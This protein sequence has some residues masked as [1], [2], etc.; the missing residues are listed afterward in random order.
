MHEEGY[1]GV[2][3][4]F[5]RLIFAITLLLVGL[6]SYPDHAKAVFSYILIDP[7]SKPYSI[8]I[9]NLTNQ[10]V[11]VDEKA[12]RI[13]IIDLET[14]AVI[15]T[16]PVGRGPK[17]VA[18]DRALNRALITNSGDQ[19]VTAVDLTTLAV[20]AKIPV[21]KSPQGIAVDDANHIAV[22]ADRKDGTLT[23]I[24]ISTLK[25]AGTVIVEGTPLDV[26]IDPALQLAVAVHEKDSTVSIIDLKSM[27]VTAVLPVGKKP[28][29]I[30]IN[31]ETHLA[32]IANEIDSSL[33]LIDLRT[34]ERS[35]IPVCKHPV[36]VAVNP[37]DNRALILCDED[38][39]LQLVDLDLKTGLMTHHLG[40]HPKSIAVNSFMN[41]AAVT[42]DETGGIAIIQLPNPVPE[43]M[44]IK[45]EAVMRGSQETMVTVN[46][47]GFI[48]GSK[49][50]DRETTMPFL[51][52]TLEDNHRL[53]VEIPEELLTY[54]GEHLI[55][56]ANPEPEGGISNAVNLT[57]MNPVP[58]ITAFEPAET[59]AGEHALTVN[60]FGTDFFNDTSVS[61][62]GTSRPFIYVSSSQI[63]VTLS[64]DDLKTGGFLEITT[65]NLPPGGGTSQPV[66]FQI[67]NA[68]PV[69]SSLSAT[70][71]QVG[72]GDVLL[73]VTGSHFTASSVVLFEATEIPA[74]HID[75]TRI[76]VTIPA[77][78]IGTAGTYKIRVIS[79][80]PGGGSS[81]SI[82]FTVVPSSPVQPLPEGSFG[83]QYEDIIPPDV[84]IQAYDAR[85]FSIVTGLVTDRHQNP[86]Q[87]VTVSVHG[88]REYGTAS[89]DITGRFSL[90]VEGG[91]IVTIEYKKDGLITSHRQVHVLWNRVAVAE[92][93]TMIPEDSKATTIAFNGD[94]S[95]I[96]SHRSSTIT[97][98]FGSRSLT[99][100]F[101]GDNRAYVRD[102]EGGE[103]V[104]SSITARATE[105]DKEES[106]PAKLPPNSA[107]T[108][109]AEL[110]IDEATNVRFEKPVTVYVDN[111]LRFPVGEAV[112]LGYYDRDRAVWVPADNGVVVVL[113][114]TNGDGVVDG[115]D[116]TG[117]ELPDDLNGN[118]SFHDEA[119][120]LE[121]PV[122]YKP[123]ATYWRV[124]IDHFTPWDCNW[125]YGP[126]GDAVMP[127]G[128]KPI[129]DEQKGE[130][131]EE[132]DCIS[133]FVK[134]PSRTF[135]EDIPIPG[136]GLTLHY[137]S[138]RV[139]GSGYKSVITIPA[140]GQTVPESLQR[141]IVKLDMAGVHMEKTLLP[142]P[143]QKAEFTWDGRDFLGRP[144]PGGVHAVI[145]VEFVYSA[146]YYIPGDFRQAFSQAG[147]PRDMPI[148]AL[149]P[150]AEIRF[151]KTY[152]TVLHLHPHPG[153]VQDEGSLSLGEGWTMSSHHSLNPANP[154][155]LFKGDGS[156]ESNGTSSINAIAG[157][158]TA[159]SGDGGPAKE[160]VLNSPVDVAVDNIGN[161]YIAETDNHCVRKIDT[162]GIISTV[163]GTGMEGFS[164][165]G[166][167]AVTAMLS[168]PTDI[169]VDESG[170]I[171]VV[172]QGNNKIRRIDRRGIITT[173]A[174]NGQYGYGGDG[175]PAT[176]AALYI[177]E[178]ITVDSM[179]NLYVADSNN[180]RIRKVDT[181]G[182]ITT[183]VGN[184][185]ECRYRLDTCG[186]RSPAVSARIGFPDGLTVDRAGNLYFS[187]RGGYLTRIRK[188]DTHG[189]ITTFA[190]SGQSGYSGDGGPAVDASLRYPADLS[191]DSAG[192]I[193]IADI[194][195]NRIRKVNTS[196][197]ITTVAGSGTRGS[198]GDGG[199]A[200]S[201]SLSSPYGAAVDPEGHLYIADTGNNRIR[202]V[203]FSTTPSGPDGT[204][205]AFNARGGLIHIFKGSGL[206]KE[207]KDAGTGVKLQT[208][209][210]DQ[211]SR[212]TS[213]TDRFGN[214]TTIQRDASGAPVSITSPDGIVTQLTIVDD[215]LLKVTYPDRSF[216]SFSYTPGG[217]MTEE[218]DPR[219][220]R[221]IH[222]FDDNGRITDVLDPEGGHWTY[223]R[224]VDSKG[225]AFVEVLTAEGNRTQH[226]E[227]T[228]STDAYSSSKTG[229]T[230]AKRTFKR[231]ADKLTEARTF[232]CG[233]SLALTYDID[234]AHR[235]KY[236][237][238]ATL[239]ST[240]G[241]SW[242]IAKSRTYTD[243][244]GDRKP[245]LLSETVAL[246]GK[247]WRRDND[248]TT[249]TV[250]NVSPVGRT[251]T[252]QYDPSML[253][254]REIAIPGMH[255]LSLSHDNRGR[256]VRAAMGQRSITY[257]YDSNGNPDFVV[258]PDN[259][260]YDYTF[261][262]VG[263]LLNEQRPDGTLI[264]Y[265]YD[266]N[267][268]MTV[269]T[270]SSFVDHGFVYTANDQRKSYRTPLS[271]SYMY[272]YDKER[273]LISVLFPSGKEIVN[274]YRNGRLNSVTSPE[275]TVA[276]DYACGSLLGNATTGNESIAYTYDGSL[277]TADTR[278]GTLN[279]VIRYEYNN[280]FSLKSLTYGGESYALTYDDDG[281]LTGAGAF[282]ITRNNLNGRPEGLSDGTLSINRVFSG[283]GELD[284]QEYTVAGTNRYG[285]TVTRD[286]SGR[287]TQKVEGLGS[288]TSTHDYGYD[289]I[290]RLVEVKKNGI[291]VETYKYDA[292]GNREKETNT[293]KNV[294][295]RVY[296]HSPEDQ[297]VTAGSHICRF[298]LDGFLTEKKVGASVTKYRYSSGGELL[299]VTTPVGTVVGYDHDPFGRR[300]AKRVNGKFVEKYLWAGRTTLLAVY[301]G[302]D[303]LMSRFA[304]AD[305]RMPVS[306]ET[307]SGTYYFMYDQVGSLRAVAD[308]SG[309]VVKRVDYD[310]FGSIQSDSN[311][312][313][314]VP[315]GF[316]GG[317]HDPDTGLVRFGARDYDPAIG[318]WTAKDPID[319]AGGDT[320][321]YGY[322]M[323]DPVNW[324]DPRGLWS[325]GKHNSII[326]R[327]VHSAMPSL[328]PAHIQAI[329]EGS[330]F[331]DTFQSPEYSYIHHM[332]NGRSNQSR[333]DAMRLMNEFI[334]NHLKEYN[335][336]EN[337]G[338]S[339]EAYK[340]LG[341]AL[342]PVM[343]S[344][345]PSHGDFLPWYGFIPLFGAAVHGASELS[346]DD[347]LTQI[348]V[349]RMIQTLNRK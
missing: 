230:G 181:S 220:S 211:S 218:I 324:V 196:G 342:H 224:T 296:S 139:K 316:A 88:H 304:Y 240:G 41:V 335:C 165:D 20:L 51:L 138:N 80:A 188:V 241:Q 92:T 202:K 66:Q 235:F 93:I 25:G 283:F 233:E 21:G 37:L 167:P 243:R 187:E 49:I 148:S 320:N 124:L 116:A 16:V 329:K 237:K 284:G 175:G 75:D 300:I 60:L 297:I 261:D 308:S 334:S 223:A 280:D 63:L 33:T 327:F 134:V 28:V 29:A 82:P 214:S 94:P 12:D 281:L 99:M 32:A 77:N 250:T 179:G 90:P 111:F 178:A 299:E 268:N 65:A 35:T 207:T 86:L 292:Q 287:I 197:I 288:E 203:L 305:D 272:S 4:F 232:P 201:A 166:G 153:L 180:Y 64:E 326:D 100:V 113:L 189:L 275:G 58:T 43:I 31:S 123:G 22:V 118:G 47:N 13:L 81:Q 248:T 294:V 154:S 269:L 19:S 85:R 190:G 71:A 312:G 170:S 112:P 298:D 185:A 325:T 336:N 348:T 168:F 282:A 104:L 162:H 330:E 132:N 1:M 72:S 314:L 3:R 40:K 8:A 183:V 45:P 69:V 215:R 263:R 79:P 57:V 98:Q 200:L 194:W 18:I 212:L 315:F 127:E 136:T 54:A 108:Y 164:G 307:G 96:I 155:T 67:R 289:T 176:A 340:H 89:T 226:Q 177:P 221:F 141:I 7:E 254:V 140:S 266:E 228:D 229:P 9:N 313:F 48:R 343:D 191:A 78:L 199:S 121:D 38:R 142:Q 115:L 319:F 270:T 236:L 143:D 39:S 242:T 61:V 303:N 23:I 73:T 144:V 302:S 151:R 278:T 150:R 290:G 346:I 53:I 333:E 146:V 101:T 158:S 137:A 106:M 344:T 231:S 114:D 206:H 205:V 318:R 15:S 293:M 122:Q 323:N 257:A 68:V 160:V 161:V 217:L 157:G 249:G 227:H 83:K 322:V 225:N 186:E 56:V 17:G 97:D 152:E 50:A 246:N 210:Y 208:F 10:A 30:D 59:S 34:S 239:V 11:V 174:G 328:E 219:G 84:T 74:R 149:R 349:N 129:V 279:Q 337:N 251:V 36:D 70:A 2:G 262:V 271:G 171:Y 110:S 247:T 301:D 216:Y 130:E 46:G 147:L 244:N 265:A 126:P 338:N 91:G 6:I 310:T 245:D 55:T 169:A 198:A 107:F 117:D 182:V 5:R 295:D 103:I 339:I 274:T 253:R 42:D 286:P 105:F 321:L 341:M 347:N 317:L 291:V 172:D 234:S 133:S 277:V 87:G 331:A 24:D 44:S 306:M 258:T 276:Y 159:D 209:S 184:G 256:L 173:V 27:N 156:Q 345:S 260:I 285:W 26:A 264:Q 109:C 195:D 311:P 76:E 193:Y 131:C 222:R 309:T 128:N 192:N 252:M 125:P 332:R 52:A 204:D 62:N 95:K 14:G 255:A 102:V 145:E 267:G 119:A 120:G 135:H 213:V 273:K 259:S 238:E 163:A